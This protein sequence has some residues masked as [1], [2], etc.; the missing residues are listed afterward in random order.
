MNLQKGVAID[1]DVSKSDAIYDKFFFYNKL[2]STQIRLYRNPRTGEW[3]GEEVDNDY[4]VRELD[5]EEIQE[6]LRYI[7]KHELRND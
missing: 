3:Y 2:T 7:P 6:Y 5:K 4:G 1:G